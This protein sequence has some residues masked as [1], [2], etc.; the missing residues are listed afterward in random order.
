[1]DILLDYLN[2]TTMGI[3]LSLIFLCVFLYR[4]KVVHGSEPPL[5]AGAWPILGHLPLLSNSKV[6]LHRKLGAI[7]ENYGPI[8]TIKLGSKHV[9]VLSN[10]EMAKECFIKND[11][12]LSSRPNSIAVETLTYN[13]AMFN[14]APYGSYWRE[15]RKIT[16]SEI[17]SNRQVDLISHVFVSE[18]KAS[19]KELFNVWSNK[20]NESE[21]VLVE[22][23]QW[24][25]QITFNTILRIVV[26]ADVVPSLRWFDF[27]GYEKAMNE[28]AKELDQILS[29]WLEEHHHNKA[30]G[31]KVEQE[32]DFMDVM[33]SMINGAKMDGFD[34]DT[35]I[36]ANTLVSI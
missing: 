34:A 26:V 30:L 28:N 8:F 13:Q 18:I 24:F 33:I 36:K 25:T 23:K 11:K 6:S 9:L 1:M 32:K 17:L 21:Y 27:G 10:W 16:T 20:K 15:L 29:E 3:L 19:I 35:I 7:A 31:E 22:L 4:P 14:F 5:V 12:V 2:A